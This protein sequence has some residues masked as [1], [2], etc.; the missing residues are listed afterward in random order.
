M[1]DNLPVVPSN[2]IN[3][4]KKE[5]ADY[6]VGFFV[7]KRLS[8]HTVKDFLE[9]FWE[10]K[11]SFDIA[12]DRDLFYFRFKCLEDKKY[13]L[14]L[15]PIFVAGRLFVVIPWSVEVEAQR[16][17]INVMPIWIKIYKVQKRLW[18]NEGIAFLASLVGKPKYIG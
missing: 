16:L 6:V 4:G 7:E 9:E 11:G 1:E 17:Q 18:T 15:G 5:W 12:A 10:L 8:F 13:F 2:I 3:E 14:G